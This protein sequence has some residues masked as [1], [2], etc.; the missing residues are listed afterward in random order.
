MESITKIRVQ[1]I[2]ELKQSI[3]SHE[4]YFALRGKRLQNNIIEASK[5]VDVTK[6][7]HVFLVQWL[8]NIK[9]NTCLFCGKEPTH[10]QTITRKEDKQPIEVRLCKHCKIEL[11]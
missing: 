7:V 1:D 4:Y 8:F 6:Q 5:K 11:T 2:N 9:D 3:M 10:V